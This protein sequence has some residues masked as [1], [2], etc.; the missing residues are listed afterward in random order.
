MAEYKG[1]NDVVSIDD[2][3]DVCGKYITNKDSLTLIKQA[4][5]FI[6]DK[7]KDQK[8]KSGEPYTNHL[9]WVA[10]I[11]ATLQTGPA[12]IA[13]G[14]LHDVMEDC[15]VSHDEMVE[16]FGLEI[17][18]LVEGVT[19]IGKMP[20]KDE[21]DVYAENHRKIY[22][23]MAKDIRVILIKF[24]DRLH[25]MRTLQYM[26]PHK[27]KRI[28][29]ETLEVYTPI[30]H[31]LGINDIKTELEDLSLYYLDPVA[32]KE[33]SNLLA[34]KQEER[35]ESVAKMMA[36]VKKM[37]D[38]NN[39]EYR[40]L[41]RAKSIYSIY[42]KMFVKKKRFDELYDLYALRIIT[43]DKMDCYSILGVIHD[44]YRPIPGRFKDYIAMPKP[45]M[46]QSLHTSVIGEDGNTFEIQIR[47]EEMDE[48]A[49]LGV[50]AHWR[51]KE[52]KGY[53]SKKEQQEIGEKLQWL[54]EFISL[55]DDIKDGDAKEY[56][57]SLKRDIFEA[58]VYVL[59]PQGKIVEL[60]NG[61]TPIDFAY[62]IHSAVGNKM[63][64][65]RVNGKMVNIDYKIQNGDQVEVVTS[66]NSNG[67]SMDWLKIVKSTQAKNKINQWFKLQNKEENIIKGKEL[68]DKYCKSKGIV[69]QDIL[70]PEYME[71]VR[72][73][74]SY[75]DWNSLVASVGHGGLKEG[76]IVNKL[77]EEYNKTHRK[78][79]T[80]QDV[81]NST[82][83]EKAEN[84]THTS[85]SGIIV[86]GMDD[87]AVR[88]SKCCSPVPGDEIIGFVTRGRGVSIHRTDC[89]NI[90]N[91][92]DFER[93]RLIEASWAADEGKQDGKYM[94]EIVIY[95]HNRVGIL[96]D[97]SKI[98]TEKNIDVNS[99]N[100]RTSKS[101][102]ATISMSFAIQ[103]TEELNSLISRIRQ[104]DSIIDIERTT[105]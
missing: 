91:L 37:L 17:T 44:H 105:G 75:K 16:R 26:P 92:P 6:M 90:I 1:A 85:K 87:V 69:L 30:A 2:I 39:Y 31:R 24:A 98:F 58:N 101:E 35:K 62:S 88:F 8:R 10:Y 82:I 77:V 40:I 103:G 23:A 79:I 78:E 86:E 73:K 59:T 33:I 56:Y 50:A 81:L 52:N 54:R 48:L 53:S 9:I 55:S 46:Y 63:V 89:I 18:T 14:L 76:Q 61:S 28:A 22:I 57:D 74:Y 94:T 27:Q 21:A 32:F 99:I 7:H 12:T 84:K 38:E 66:N 49:E 60:P 100:S 15:N 5:D 80:D 34:V 65:A 95:A 41:G 47:T 29:R 97:L 42:K 96:T 93:G 104:I 68:I 25:N 20:F 72:L 36:K 83:G 13:A 45:N 19:K 71:K 51:Y 64:G 67:P 11:L 102:I 4:Y 43:K 70:K 3:L